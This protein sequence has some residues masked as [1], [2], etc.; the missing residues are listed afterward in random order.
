[1]SSKPDLCP[2]CQHVSVLFRIPTEIQRSLYE[3][4]GPDGSTR[5]TSDITDHNKQGFISQQIRRE[6]CAKAPQLMQGSEI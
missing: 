3:S 6:A 5:R 4:P 1:M 2:G